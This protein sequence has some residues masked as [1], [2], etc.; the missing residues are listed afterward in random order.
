MHNDKVVNPL[1]YL[2]IADPETKAESVD[3]GFAE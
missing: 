3:L 2:D 1:N